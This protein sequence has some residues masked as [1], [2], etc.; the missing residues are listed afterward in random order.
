M[1]EKFPSIN[2]S[3]NEDLTQKIFQKTKDFNIK[4]PNYDLKIKLR[5]DDISKIFNLNKINDV[6]EYISFS[7]YIKENN[8]INILDEILSLKEQ[9]NAKIKEDID[10]AIKL[11]DK[12]IKI[13]YD[14]EDNPNKDTNIL[15]QVVNQKKLILSN[16]SQ[17]LLKQKKYFPSI[18][19]DKYIIE[20]VD[21]KFD[22]SYAR[23][24]S[25]YLSLDDLS[26]AKYYAE[27]MK[28]LFNKEI[29]DKYS[30]IINRLNEKEEQKNI[31][32]KNFYKKSKKKENKIIQNYKENL[33][34]ETMK[35][36]RNNFWSIMFHTTMFLG[37]GIALY[38]LYKK[39]KNFI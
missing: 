33:V 1:D 30:D 7:N 20:N 15:K 35:K 22:K 39:R 23:L 8:K 19:I 38:I 14:Y 26:D 29:V 2:D 25:N 28:H 21:N 3:N 32:L 34:N 18:E 16:K 37:S 4:F 11:Y 13:I 6:N 17:M 10:E 12:A 24:I 9:G 27:Q 31:F 36:K 5:K